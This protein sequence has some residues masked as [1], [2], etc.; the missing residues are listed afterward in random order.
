LWQL[1]TK[2]EDK[3]DYELLQTAS[4]GLPAGRP[5]WPE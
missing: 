4:Q 3:T 5:G 1:T 2:A